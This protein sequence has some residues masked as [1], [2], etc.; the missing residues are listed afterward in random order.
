MRYCP[1]CKADMFGGSVCDR[2]GGRLAEKQVDT[3]ART[4]HVTRDMIVGAPKKLRSELAQSLS[5]RI[6]R[7]VVE[8]VVFCAIFY[9]AVWVLHVIANFLSVQMSDD[10]E[11]ATE[12]IYWGSSGVHYF[13]YVGWAI[14]AILAI[15]TRWGAGK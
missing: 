5:G 6:F 11:T 1:R 9:A 12:P 14:I 15:R 2:C 13:L 7:L 10:P 8:I 3:G 4:V